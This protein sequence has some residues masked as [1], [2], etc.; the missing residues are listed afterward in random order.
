MLYFRDV[1]DSLWP[2]THGPL[3]NDGCGRIVLGGSV[4]L[5]G[6]TEPQATAAFAALTTLLASGLSAGVVRLRIVGQTVRAEA[7]NNPAAYASVSYQ[8]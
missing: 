4:T 8:P 5:F 1:S 2:A 6:G 3:H 7:V